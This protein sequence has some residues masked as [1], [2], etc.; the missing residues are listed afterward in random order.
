[1]KPFTWRS[2]KTHPGRSQPVRTRQ[3]WRAVA[4][5]E[6]TVTD[7]ASAVELLERDV[8]LVESTVM[9]IKITT[10]EDLITA[11]GILSELKGSP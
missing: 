6:A 2:R 8:H 3:G 4:K 1:M 9:N 7:E 5:Q 11:R 10:P